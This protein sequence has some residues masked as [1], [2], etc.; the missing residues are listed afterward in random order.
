MGREPDRRGGWEA[1]GLPFDARTILAAVSR[2]IL[3]GT[4]RRTASASKNQACMRPG[5]LRVSLSGRHAARCLQGVLI[6]GAGNFADLVR[7]RARLFKP[8]VG[9]RGPVCPVQGNSPIA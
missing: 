5:D 6:S 2:E 9:D 7:W 3:P 1:G 4:P 8:R